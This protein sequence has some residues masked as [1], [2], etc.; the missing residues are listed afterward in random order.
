MGPGISCGYSHSYLDSESEQHRQE[1][2]R[3]RKVVKI[4]E[5]WGQGSHTHSGCGP[6][7]PAEE[8]I[9]RE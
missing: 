5:I 1:Q 7:I 3:T 6:W 8:E 9:Y 2:E 4:R